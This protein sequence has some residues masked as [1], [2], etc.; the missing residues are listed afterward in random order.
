MA[1]PI[2]LRVDFQGGAASGTVPHLLAINYTSSAVLLLE[3]R[4]WLKQSKTCFEF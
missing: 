4:N 2:P 3:E 1:V